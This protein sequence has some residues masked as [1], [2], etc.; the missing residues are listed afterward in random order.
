M[1]RVTNFIPLTSSDVRGKAIVRPEDPDV[2]AL[3]NG[4]PTN[5]SGSQNG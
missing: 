1:R 2:V 3:R 4:Q 5:A